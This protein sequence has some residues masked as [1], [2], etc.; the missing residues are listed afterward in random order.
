MMK[1]TRQVPA[2]LE[3]G[4]MVAMSLAKIADGTWSSVETQA[5][6]EGQAG[7]LLAHWTPEQKT[8]VFKRIIVACR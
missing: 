6:W 8:D 5:D 1:T 3:M 4:C 2:E 7:T